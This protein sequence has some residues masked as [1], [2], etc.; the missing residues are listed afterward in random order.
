MQKL[1]ERAGNSSRGSI[2]GFYAVLVEGDDF[3]EPVTDRV[4][5][6]I[7]GHIMLTRPLADR[8]HYPPIDISGSLSRW[9]ND[10]MGPQTRKAAVAIRRLIADYASSQLMIEAGAYKSGT[11][12]DVDAAVTKRPDIEQFLIQDERETST[13]EE[14]LTEMGRIAEI[15]ILEDEMGS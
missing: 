13:L 14:T 1:L 2:T 10:I 4:R 9:A 3:D 8:G 15:E 6:V 5:S 11:N 7:D 12:A